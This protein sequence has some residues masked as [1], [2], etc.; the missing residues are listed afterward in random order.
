MLPIA[1]FTL[2]L[3]PNMSLPQ[4]EVTVPSKFEQTFIYPKQLNSFPVIRS[5]WKFR[6]HGKCSEKT[7]NQVRER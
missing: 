6:E 2:Q 3:L 7:N 1:S 4:L 5:D